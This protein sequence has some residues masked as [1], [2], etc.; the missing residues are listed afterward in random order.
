MK[1]NL[2]LLFLLCSAV[3]LS[4]QDAR[5]LK[6]VPKAEKAQLKE[7]SEKLVHPTQKSLDA[8]D[9][10]SFDPKTT[11]I[12]KASRK[13]VAAVPVALYDRP[14]GVYLGSIIGYSDPDYLGYSW[15]NPPL[16]GAAYVPW[17]LRN[18]STDATSYEWTWGGEVYSTA[19][20]PAF[21]TQYT[22]GTVADFLLQGGWYTPQLKA[23]AGA[24][25][26]TYEP[27]PGRGGSIFAASS[28]T[29]DVSN[30]DFYGNTAEADNANHISYY[31]VGAAG[32]TSND[33]SGD[34][35]FW[36]SAYRS[37]DN[38]RVNSVVNIYEKPISPVVIKDVTAFATTKVATPVPS[39]KSLKLT[40]YK[41]D[42]DGNVT[43][44]VL[45]TAKPLSGSDVIIDAPN[46]GY[47]DT[48]LP[49]TFVET[50]PET[51]RTKD[52]VLVI[53]DPFAV[54]ISGFDQDGVNLGL[55]S[56][57]D[58]QIDLKSFF[59]R[60][61]ETTGVS[62]GKLYSA[63]GGFAMNTYVMLNVYFNYLYADPDTQTTTAPNAGGYAVDDTYG[64]EGSIVYSFFNAGDVDDNDEPLIWYDETTLPSWLTIG[65]DDQFYEEYNA[66]I[67]VFDALA[68][69]NGV[70]GRTANVK[71]QSYGAETVLK[72]IQGDGGTTA[73]SSV[74]TEIT[75]AVRQGNNFV[76][77]YPTSASSVSVYNVAGQRVGE[78]KLNATG[79]YTLPAA[80][81]ANG[82]YVLKF[83]NGTSVKV[84]K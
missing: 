73:I 28:S 60:V 54:V 13:S 47:Y 24:S 82:A 80:N 66:L 79:T 62:D 83:N 11:N 51:G 34:G 52:V 30:A 65:V 25:S 5:F 49:F 2:L 72:I 44:E 42:G 31:I 64:D 27:Y 63:S 26:S 71:I 17:V 57:Y 61:N 68:L 69:P 78:Y 59:T 3:S 21:V 35:Y 16:V 67:F 75:K 10:Q 36:G 76:L 22:N 33:H 45:G 1:K 70:S 50:D 48:Y 14:E 43:D 7:K 39:N 32:A 74:K 40:V 37:A 18:L 84:L 23:I 41:V 12:V 46:G 29:Y 6:V 77:S 58:N 15:N 20:N 81:L 19:T 9:V 4:A 53:N 38:T 56:D 8:Y 55:L